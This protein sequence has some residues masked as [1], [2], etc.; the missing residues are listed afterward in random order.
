MHANVNI[1][2]RAARR[3]GDLIMRHLSRVDLLHVESKGRQ[4]FVTAVD[5]EAEAAIIATLQ[6]AYPD[7]AILAEE[8]GQHGSADRQW[9][10]DPLD[11]TTNFLHG[12]PQFAVSI[13][14]SE[15][16]VLR[17]AVIYDPTRDELFTASRGQGAQLNNRRIRVSSLGR[18]ERA[19]IGTGFPSRNRSLIDGYVASFRS[20]LG[21]CSGIRR[22]GAAAIDLA[23][24]A[25]GRLDCFWEFGLQPWDIAA[26][27]LLIQ[28][29]GGV[30]CTP[31]GGDDYLDSGNIVTGN[32]KL[33]ESL[34][35][36]VARGG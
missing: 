6:D 33:C 21:T 3:A 30:V 5:R 31:E 14:L 19:L 29:A 12:F 2:I 1:A 36:V 16:G 8:S 27:V 9:I 18:L 15:K 25:C 34:R 10:V 22:G 13:A 32:P 11:G 17:H 7:D 20:L 23:Y 26:G 35:R 24:V 4:D 28:E